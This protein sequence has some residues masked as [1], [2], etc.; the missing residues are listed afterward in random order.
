V[1]FAPL[2]ALGL[3]LAAGAGK[4][5]TPEGKDR[6]GSG[7]VL[8]A[9]EMWDLP[10]AQQRLDELRH[11]EGETP[12]TRELTGR[13]RFFAGDYAGAVESLQDS[14]SLYAGLAAATL[15]ETRNDEQRESAHFV[16]RYPPGKDEIL[17]PYALETLEAARERIGRDLG[18][19]PEER[20][21][22][23]ILRDPSALSRLSPLTETE[24]A[25]SGTIAL[26]KYDKLMVVSPRAL[27]VGYAWQDTLA[28]ELTHYLITRKS[29]NKTPIWLHEGIAKYEESHWRGEAGEALS[30]STAALLNRRL[31]DGSLISFERMHPSIAMLPSQEDAAL[32]FAEVFTTIEY[33][34][35]E[36]HASL[37][38][39]LVSLSQGM[40]DTQA[41][42]HAAGE[43][44]DR[45]TRDWKAYLQRRPMPKELAPLAPEKLRFKSDPDARDPEPDGA[46]PAIPD[47]QA[48]RAAHLGSLLLARARLNPALIELGKAEGRVGARSS[49]LSNLYAKALLQA[50]RREEAERVLRASLVPYPD[51][52]QTHLQLGQVELGAQRWD[53]A[54][55]ELLAANAVDP[56]DPEIHVGLLKVAQVQRDA[57]AETRESHAVTRLEQH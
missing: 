46:D 57:A 45:L 48:R 15:A 43:S 28:H 52:A 35:K 20:I 50:G 4:E 39:L 40:G 18:F 25:Q 23:E 38:Q 7:A 24:I 13:L 56:F 19:L 44:F 10:L 37:E 49:V 6:A 22:V 31:K 9:L 29:Q 55:Q 8:E 26:C 34:V 54:K 27:V 51:I 32:A 16:L 3:A 30:P 1:T 17:A 14:G 5:T 12:V 2:I 11:A 42:E 21:R 36:R 47:P 33:L 41:V 53:L